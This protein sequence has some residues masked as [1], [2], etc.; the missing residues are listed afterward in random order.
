MRILPLLAVG[1]VFLAGCGQETSPTAITSGVTGLVQLGPQCPVEI[2][3]QPCDD[4]PA[5][6]V[7]VT[8]SKQAPGEAY[9]AG[10]PVAHGTTDDE[11]RFRIDVG[12]G[13]YVVTAQAGMSCEFM[14]V[15]V[16][17][18]DYATVDVP[19]DTGIR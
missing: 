13:E 2:E 14:D 8:V 9:G 10:E 16:T 11:G 18:G 1:I 7:E 5:A 6:G 17:D 4:Q 3:G 12:P 19:C 15:R